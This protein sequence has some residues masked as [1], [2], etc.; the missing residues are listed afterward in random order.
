[1]ILDGVEDMVHKDFERSKVNFLS[2]G[3][4]RVLRGLFVDGVERSVLT[5]LWEGE[6]WLWLSP[7]PLEERS[8]VLRVI[9]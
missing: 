1:M 7:S 9:S 6:L 3:V 5:P 8:T 2:I 4:G